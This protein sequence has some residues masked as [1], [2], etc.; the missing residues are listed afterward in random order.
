MISDIVQRLND[1]AVTSAAEDSV[2]ALTQAYTEDLLLEA[3]V[4]ITQLRA[5]PNTR[6]AVADAEIQRLREEAMQLQL[7][8]VERWALKEAAHAC[9]SCNGF[10]NNPAVPALY[11]GDDVAAA[12]NSIL[13]RLTL[14]GIMKKLFDYDHVEKDK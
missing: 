3:A 2:S 11:K 14:K 10:N 9:G 13:E 4:E 1:R 7:T 12:L 8:A 5:A 6:F